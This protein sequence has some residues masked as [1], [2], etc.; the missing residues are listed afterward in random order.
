MVIT[1]DQGFISALEIL[2]ARKVELERAI[3]SQLDEFSK[4]TGLEIEE[5]AI[6]HV[7][8]LD[9]KPI[10]YIVECHVQI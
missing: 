3:R 1:S 8:T 2:K 10:G 7:R 4:E 5:I 6:C 9:E